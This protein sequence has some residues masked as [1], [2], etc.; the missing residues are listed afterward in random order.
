MPYFSGGG[1]LLGVLDIDSDELD[2]FREIDSQGLRSIC[3]V[4]KDWNAF[5]EHVS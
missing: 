2:A 3:S 4:F 1:E 5:R